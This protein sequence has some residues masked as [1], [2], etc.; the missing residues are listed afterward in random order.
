MDHERTFTIATHSL[1]M[2]LMSGPAQMDWHQFSFD[3]VTSQPNNTITQQYTHDQ[4][5]AGSTNTDVLD[6]YAILSQ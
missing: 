3:H 4:T 1:H 6:T 2:T 5:L